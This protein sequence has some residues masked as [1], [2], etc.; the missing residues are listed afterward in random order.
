MVKFR[1]VLVTRAPV[2]AHR[3]RESSDRD[4]QAAFE[5]EKQ[6]AHRLRL[7]TA[8]GLKKW[9]MVTSCYPLVN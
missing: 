4:A 5:E 7:E 3:V 2:E 9:V 6:K 1:H 8:G